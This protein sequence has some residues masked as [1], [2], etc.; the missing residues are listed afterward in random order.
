M[1]SCLHETLS[2]VLSVRTLTGLLCKHEAHVFSLKNES[3][4]DFQGILET[5]SVDALKCQRQHCR[6]KLTARS[7]TT[8]AKKSN[9]DCI[10]ALCFIA[11]PKKL[12]FCGLLMNLSETSHGDFPPQRRWEQAP[13]VSRRKACPRT[14]VLRSSDDTLCNFEQ[15]SRHET[16]DFALKCSDPCGPPWPRQCGCISMPKGLSAKDVSERPFVMN[17]LL[18]SRLFKKHQVDGR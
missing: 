7:M 5:R 15:A 12:V 18:R 4:Q 6:L 8:V 10:S 11:C 13:C 2:F 14:G 3:G 9:A 16:L 1:A 17:T